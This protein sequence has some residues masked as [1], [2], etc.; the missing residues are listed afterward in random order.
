MAATQLQVNQL[1]AAI[2]ALDVKIDKLAEIEVLVKEAHQMGSATQV[3][4]SELSAVI[5]SKAKSATPSTSEA[6]QDLFAPGRFQTAGILKII[7]EVLA[8]PDHPQY[9]FID[10]F[11]KRLR[12]A[13][14]DID[15]KFVIYDGQSAE[16]R[17][18]QQTVC[19]NILRN[20][21]FDKAFK[22]TILAFDDLESIKQTF[23]ELAPVP[24]GKGKGKASSSTAPSVDLAALDAI[25]NASE[26][27]TENAFKFG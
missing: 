24:K 19:M 11:V 23:D 18:D 27:D 6:K 9:A 15:S 16:I 5:N 4:L 26:F 20:T 1:I 7:L 10:G 3:K 21:T 13:K 14:P 22:E 17:R 8:K 2:K 25:G 12:K